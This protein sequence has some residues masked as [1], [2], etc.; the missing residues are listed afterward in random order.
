MK[1]IF[2]SNYLIGNDKINILHGM[3]LSL[4]IRHLPTLGTLIQT[5]QTRVIATNAHINAIF[6]NFYEHQMF[7]KFCY[8]V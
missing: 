2:C 5:P 1:V 3:P 7:S 8:H 4:C 6:R